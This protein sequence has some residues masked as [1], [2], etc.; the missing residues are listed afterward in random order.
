MQPEQRNV[1][2]MKDLVAKLSQKRASVGGTVCGDVFGCESVHGAFK[3]IMVCWA[4][5]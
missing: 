2:C 4:Q 1:S 5:D 3:A